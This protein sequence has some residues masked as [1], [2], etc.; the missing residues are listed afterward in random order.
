MTLI[1]TIQGNIGGGKSTFLNHLK[2]LYKDNLNICFLQEP[3]EEWLSIRDTSGVSIL[4]LF[5]AEQHKYAFSFQ[6]M[7]YIS[8]LAI[9]K[10]AFNSGY[11]IIISERSLETDRNIFE[12]MLYDDDKIT[13]IEH[14]IYSKWFDTF[15]YDFPEEYVFYMH[16]TPQIIYERI[17]KRDRKGE[18]IPLEYLKTCH[19]YHETWVD[20]LPL[21]RVS[22]IDGNVDFNDEPEILN[23]WVSQLQSFI[24]KCIPL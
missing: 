12:K 9:L 11:E 15:K 5:Y 20:S 8:R 24:N 4:E 21:D 2:T 10:K 6:M 3:V 16:T 23:L 14:Q 19:V 1:I 22:I 17:Q 13:H 7:A 18:L